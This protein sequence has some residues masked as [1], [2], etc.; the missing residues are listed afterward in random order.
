MERLRIKEGWGYTVYP[1]AVFTRSDG[2]ITGQVENRTF[3]KVWLRLEGGRQAEVDDR[4]IE[5]V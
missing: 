3:T 5:Y 4:A 1:N 2:T